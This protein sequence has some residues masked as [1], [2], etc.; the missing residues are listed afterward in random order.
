MGGN[1][2]LI[3]LAIV[4]RVVI[5]IPIAIINLTV[6]LFLELGLVHYFLVADS[7]INTDAY[8]W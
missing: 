3:G 4:I 7:A 5:T 1:L 2:V 8:V 6:G